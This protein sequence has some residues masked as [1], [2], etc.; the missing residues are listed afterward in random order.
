MILN[1]KQNKPFL[2]LDENRFFLLLD[3]CR[4][5]ILFGRLVNDVLLADDDC[6]VLLSS[7]STREPLLERR[8]GKICFLANIHLRKS[9]RG[10]NKK[11]VD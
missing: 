8:D 9:I 2:V 3:F 10:L 1:W 4:L 5:L 7:A 11:R 6:S